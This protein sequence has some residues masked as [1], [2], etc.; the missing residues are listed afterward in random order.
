MTQ[1]AERAL[2]ARVVQWRAMPA[3]PPTGRPCC[4]V[5]P[6]RSQRME[7]RRNIIDLAWICAREIASGHRPAA[8]F[9]KTNPAELIAKYNQ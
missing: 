2:R 8:D 7:N 4:E 1:R 3:P 5:L 9:V 6:K